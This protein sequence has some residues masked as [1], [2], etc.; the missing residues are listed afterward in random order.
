MFNSRVNGAS[1]SPNPGALETFKKTMSEWVVDH[2]G[3]ARPESVPDMLTNSNRLSEVHP[4]LERIPPWLARQIFAYA[5]LAVIDLP[6][7]AAHYA[8]WARNSQALVAKVVY[9]IYRAYFKLYIGQ[10]WSKFCILTP[11]LR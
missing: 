2:G 4:P 5:A 7:D 10:I 1:R 3:I 9:E 8:F 6:T 11:V